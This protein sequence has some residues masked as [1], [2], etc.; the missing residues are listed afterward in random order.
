M[1]IGIYKI[2]SPKGKIYVGQS[3]NIEKRFREHKNSINKKQT[4][5]YRSLLKYGYSSHKFEIIEECFIKQLD[6]REIYWKQ[7]YLDLFNNSW[8]LVLFHEIYDAGGGP[9]SD[10][11]KQKIS[12]ANSKPKPPGF[13]DK[14]SKAIGQYNLNGEFIKKWDS[15]TEAKK[16]I[17]GDILSCCQHKQKTAGGF[18]WE[19]YIDTLNINVNLTNKHTGVKKTDKW[20]KNKYKPINQYDLEGNFIREWESMKQIVKE[21]NYSQS[22]ISNCCRG[23]YKQANNYIWKF[24]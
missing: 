4:K 23:I 16:H 19:Y 2:T 5:L 6:E 10:F 8:K 20:V 9:K 22:G 14:I 7:H 17:K 11:T 24:K 12:K 3:I 18:I 21:L 15:I 13:G 1:S